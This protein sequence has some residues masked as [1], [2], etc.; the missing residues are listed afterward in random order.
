VVAPSLHRTVEVSAYLA[1]HALAA[2][3]AL[4]LT[5]FMEAEVVPLAHDLAVVGEHPR[6]LP[7]GSPGCSARPP[8][9]RDRARGGRVAR[10]NRRSRHAPTHQGLHQPRTNAPAEA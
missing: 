5:N 6:E 7:A 2:A 8:T 3:F 1:G 10:T 9:P 4:A